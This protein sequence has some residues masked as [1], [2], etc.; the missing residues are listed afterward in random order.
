MAEADFPKTAFRSRYGHYQFKV[1][2]F[3]LTNAPATFQTAMNNIFRP[4]LD[5][6]VVVFLDDIFVF[7]KDASLHATHLDKVLGILRDHNYFARLHKCSFAEAAVE[8]LGHI[9]SFSTIAMD[10]SKIQ[11]VTDWPRPTTVRHIRSFL[12]LAG[13]YRRFIKNFA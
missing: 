10:P 11:A 9:I 5:E 4:Y 13:Y 2:P 1:M 3:G 8:F 7:S 6:F 12:G